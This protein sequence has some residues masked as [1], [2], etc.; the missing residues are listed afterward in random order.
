MCYFALLRGLPQRSSVDAVFYPI[1]SLCLE[2]TVHVYCNL[3]VWQNS[4]MRCSLNFEFGMYDVT[5]CIF[6]FSNVNKIT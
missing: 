5:K 3:Y 1:F 2:K 6:T 4:C